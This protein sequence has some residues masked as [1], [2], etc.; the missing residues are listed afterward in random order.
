MTAAAMHR[1][2]MLWGPLSALGVIAA[3]LTGAAD[4]ASK[5]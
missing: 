1:T 4:Q 3:L 2:R 5:L